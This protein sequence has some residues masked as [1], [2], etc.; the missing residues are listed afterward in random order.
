[1]RLWK[2]KRS[3]LKNDCYCILKYT[4]FNVLQNCKRCSQNHCEARKEA[5]SCWFDRSP[6]VCVEISGMIIARKL[7]RCHGNLTHCY[8]L[9]INYVYTTKVIH[10]DFSDACTAELEDSHS[11]FLV[12]RSKIQCLELTAIQILLV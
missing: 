5:R 8:F 2:E 11:D 10:S 4:Y 9:A 6:T 7:Q 1:L 3:K 12:R